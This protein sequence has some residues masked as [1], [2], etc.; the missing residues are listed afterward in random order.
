MNCD[1]FFDT[2][3][4][5]LATVIAVYEPS[6]S[7][8]DPKWCDAMRLEINAL[9]SR[10]RLETLFS[11]SQENRL[12]TASGYNELIIRWMTL[13]STIRRVW[14]YLGI[15]SAKLLTLLTLSLQ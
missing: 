4:Q 13:F 6:E 7:I 11:F 3:E 12:S 15:Q 2:H 8:T 9:G 10:I 14:S 1:K 5:F